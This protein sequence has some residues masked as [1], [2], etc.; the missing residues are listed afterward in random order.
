MAG[1]SEME[2][3]SDAGA[4]TNAKSHVLPAL[5]VA[6]CGAIWGGYW[7][8]LRSF[9]D[10]G[11]GSAWVSLVFNAAGIMVLLPWLWSR[12]ALGG[13][14]AQALTGLLIGTAFTLYT[15]SLVLTDVLHAILLFYL[16]PVWSTLAGWVFLG[17]RLTVGRIL[18]ILLGLAG[19]VS[20]LGQGKG[21]PMPR[22]AGD[23]I[24]L[25]SGMLWA[26]GTMRSYSRPAEGIAMPVLAFSVGGLISSGVILGIA[27][28]LSQP[29]A[30]PG[31]LLPALPWLLLLALIIFVPPNFLVLWAAQRMDAGRVGILLMTEVMVGA[32]T[33]ALFSG[34]AF[35]PSE[36]I[37]TVLIVSAA[38]IEV[39][40]RR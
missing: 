29:L 11:V 40:G 17:H 27:F 16:T 25:A 37:G 28:A 22:N 13:F 24:A 9:A 26:F 31:P 12:R 4:S 10:Q 18:S 14:P 8:P 2:P 23:A 15:V 35:G 20:I 38:L 33:A 32:V 30:E 19:M 39:L 1:N 34:E 7:I 6:L 36:V 21:L 5:A 3:M